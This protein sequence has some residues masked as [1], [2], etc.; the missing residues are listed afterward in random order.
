[1]SSLTILLKDFLGVR[2]HSL[3][4]GLIGL[5]GLQKAR[6]ARL[7]FPPRFL[8]LL[9]VKLESGVFAW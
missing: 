2:F 3:W 6:V 5:C 4:L 7:F 1:M 9:G 8:K